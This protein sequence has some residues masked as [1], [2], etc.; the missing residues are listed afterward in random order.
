MPK[1]NRH[2]G[3]FSFLLILLLT[4]G[5]C[6]DS[7]TGV[8]NSGGGNGDSFDHRQGSGESSAAFLRSENFNHLL[9]ELD[10]VESQRPTDRALDSLESMLD[11][12]LHK[13]GGIT[14]SVSSNAIGPGGED[15]YTPSDIRSLEENHRDHYTQGDTLAAYLL[16][17]DGSYQQ[18]NVLGVAYYNTSMALMEEKIQEHSGGISQ[19][20]RYK[21]EAT[22]LQH[23]FGH[24]LGLV[25]NGTPTQSD[26][27]TEESRHC[28]ADGC[29]M[30]PAVKTSDF[31]AN[32]F[33]GTIPDFDS[34]CL[35]DLQ[36]HGG[37]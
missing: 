24:V 26:H 12:R 22:V 21:I 30:Q 20:P 35:A 10:Y 27:K 17:L 2:I 8:N 15:T 32:V 36:A 1:I 13:P 16:F 29:L 9:I 4:A 14:I 33:D 23:E 31:F 7:S 19:P 34:Q 3:L 28:T 5:G 6:S 37:K 11:K 18:E 25:A